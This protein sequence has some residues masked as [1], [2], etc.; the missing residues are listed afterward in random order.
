MRAPRAVDQ[1]EGGCAAGGSARLKPAGHGAAAAGGRLGGADRREGGKGEKRRRRESSPEGAAATGAE[2]EGGGDDRRCRGADGRRRHPRREQRGIRRGGDDHGGLKCRPKMETMASSPANVGNGAPASFGGNQTAAEVR[3]GSVS[4]MAV[5][6]RRGGGSSGGGVRPEIGGGGGARADRHERATWEGERE[7]RGFKMNL[8]HFMRARGAG[9]A[10][11]RAVTR[12]RRGVG[13]GRDGKG[14]GVGGCRRGRGWLEVG[15]DPTGG[16]HLSA[17]RR[18]EEGA[19]AGPRRSGA[20]A[21]DGVD[22]A[23]GPRRGKK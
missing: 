16:A 21:G 13:R 4:A 2:N 23:D 8:A 14:G 10:G 9:D 3:A 22:W 19:R 6:A 7:G 20:R 12:A 17:S 1:R 5:M 15:D 18:E 11:E